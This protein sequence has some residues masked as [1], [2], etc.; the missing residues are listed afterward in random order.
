MKKERTKKLNW[1]K[2][3][4]KLSWDYI[5]DSRRFIYFTICLFVVFILLGYFRPVYFVDIIRKMLEDIVNASQ[6]LNTFQMIIFILENN[7]KNAFIGLMVG[8]LFGIFPLFT[9]VANGYVLG[10]VGYYASKQAG[11]GVLWQLLPHGIFELPALILALSLGVK[12][13]MF[14]FYKKK[15]T[16]KEEFLYRLD[17]SLR[18]FIFIILPLL[19]IAGI[20][21]GLLIGAG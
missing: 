6:G 7:I 15:K 21:E 2:N 20:I 16:I 14:L 5:K 13:G 12:F 9:L 17:R 3:N 1:F 10:F 18:V 4:L 19:I 11:L 8:V